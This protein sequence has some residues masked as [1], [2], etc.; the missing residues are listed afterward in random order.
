MNCN[1]FGPAGFLDPPFGFCKTGLFMFR[2]HRWLTEYGRDGDSPNEANR[3][4]KM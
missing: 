1:G 4:M 2:G 3:R